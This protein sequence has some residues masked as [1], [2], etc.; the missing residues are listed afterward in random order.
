M[1]NLIARG[2][3]GEKVVDEWRMLGGDDESCVLVKVHVAKRLC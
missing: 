2:S 1:M 3:V